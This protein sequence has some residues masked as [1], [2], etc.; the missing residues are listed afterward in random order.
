MDA[1]KLH[2]RIELWG[3]DLVR[4]FLSANHIQIPSIF[5]N[6]SAWNFRFTYQINLNDAINVEDQNQ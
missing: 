5:Y 6:I 2:I 3:V 1:I 4:E